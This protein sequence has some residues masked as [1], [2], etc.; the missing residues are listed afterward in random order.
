MSPL[1]N[2]VLAV[3]WGFSLAG[4]AWCCMKAAQSIS[5]VT[6]A[7]GQRTELRLPIIIRLLLPLTPNLTPHLVA[8]SL[9]PMKRRID[10]KL[11]AAGFEEVMTSSDFLAIRVLVPIVMAPVL[12]ALLWSAIPTIHGKVGLF[13]NKQLWLLCIMAV[14]T[15]IA[16]PASWLQKELADRHRNIQRSLP[17]ILDLLTLSV[18]AGMDFMSGLQRIVDRRKLDAMCEELI[19]VLREIQLGK[20]RRQAL[21][22]MASRVS[23]PDV[24]SVVN[25]LI[26]ADEM[27]A[28]IGKTLRIQADQMRMK[29][30]QRAEKKAYEAPIKML[31]PLIMFIFP[32]VFLVLLGP[33]FYQ[34][35][36]RIF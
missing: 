18:E 9:E 10:R 3:L 2:I 34:M 12:I 30:F 17:F 16:Y 13:L 6:L 14:I 25:A 27:G 5:Y 19:R 35:A 4:F 24:T 32:A 20:T 1:F 28:S 31:F 22:G 23:Q 8:P 15:S 11:V 7:D 33:V 21:I 26:Q 29:R 36:Q